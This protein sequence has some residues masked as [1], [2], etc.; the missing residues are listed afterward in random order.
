[1]LTSDKLVQRDRDGGA[2]EIALDDVKSLHEG[3]GWLLVTGGDS[4]KGIAIPSRVEGFEQI[5]RALTAHCT[6]TPIRMTTSKIP[7]IA[8]AI[9]GLTAMVAVFSHSL[10]VILTSS[11]IILLVWPFWI[12]YSPR[13]VWQTRKVPNR[14]VVAYSLVWLLMF[15]YIIFRFTAHSF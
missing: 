14:L 4:S 5:G 12:A 10:A 1:M 6:E 13:R 15:G 7:W 8:E 2:V 3:R 9:F 11:V